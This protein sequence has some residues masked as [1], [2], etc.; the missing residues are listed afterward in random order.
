M[1]T[2]AKLIQEIYTKRELQEKLKHTMEQGRRKV[3]KQALRLY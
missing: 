1:K 2:I 3:Y